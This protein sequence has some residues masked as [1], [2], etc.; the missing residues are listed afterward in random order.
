MIPV[1]AA[2]G[3]LVSAA[4]IAENTAEASISSILKGAA[5]IYAQNVSSLS[6]V[7]DIHGAVATNVGHIDMSTYTGPY[8]ENVS[9]KAPSFKTGEFNISMYH[10]QNDSN[11]SKTIKLLRACL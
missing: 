8:A 11:F 7:R 5:R 2:L 10:T 3:I 4:P 1:T 9:Y 6:I